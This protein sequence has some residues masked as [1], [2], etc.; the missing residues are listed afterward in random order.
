[1]HLDPTCTSPK[2]VYTVVNSLSS[3]TIDSINRVLIK[4]L[5]TASK[6]LILELKPVNNARSGSW[7][8]KPW[9]NPD[10]TRNHAV[11]HF[12]DNVEMA[13]VSAARNSNQKAQQLATALIHR[14]DRSAVL[15]EKLLLGNRLSGAEQQEIHA[16]QDVSP[17]LA[18]HVD[19]SRGAMKKEYLKVII[20]VCFRGATC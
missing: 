6:S 8:V 9:K 13:L 14:M 3:E 5:D 15:T 20:K 10:G 4:T 18:G 17:G 11:E 19:D 1:M 16:A 2:D 7:R 12:V